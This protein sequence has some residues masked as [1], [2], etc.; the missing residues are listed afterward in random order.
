MPSLNIES[1]GTKKGRRFNRKREIA[2]KSMRRR[3]M[4]LKKEKEEMRKEKESIEEGQRRVRERMGDVEEEWEQ[5]TEETNEIFRQT[6][7]TRIRLALMLD[8]LKAR[9]GG[10]VVEA[11]HL[12]RLLRLV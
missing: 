9:Q 1:I 7:T 6:A 2:K 8:I 4:R 12:T 11:S 10:D 3:L 5:I